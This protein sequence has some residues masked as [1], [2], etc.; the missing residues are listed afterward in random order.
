MMNDYE[1]FMDEKKVTVSLSEPYCGGRGEI[2]D[3]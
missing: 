1:N 3:G 2:M